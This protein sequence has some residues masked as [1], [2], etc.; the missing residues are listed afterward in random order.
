MI[1]S[2]NVQVINYHKVDQPLFGW[3]T[4][5]SKRLPSLLHVPPPG[6]DQFVV[7]WEPGREG[8]TQISLQWNGS[9]AEKAG[10][11][12]VCS[13]MGTWQRR[14]DPDQLVVEWEPGREGRT[15]I[16]L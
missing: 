11:R 14:Q 10:P 7:E 2:G 6:C 15:Q 16:S 3:L 8:R 4:A 13:G 5:P 9:L 12:S 1:L